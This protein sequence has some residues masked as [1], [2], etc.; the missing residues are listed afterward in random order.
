MTTEGNSKNNPK[1]FKEGQAQ[2]KPKPKLKEVSEVEAKL[3][4]L[5]AEV[6]GRADLAS[7]PLSAPAPVDKPATRRSKPPKPKAERYADDDED[8]NVEPVDYE[9]PYADDDPSWGF[10]KKRIA[11]SPHINMAAFWAIAILSILLANAPGVNVLLT[12]VTQFVVMIHECSHAIVAVLTGGHPAVTIVSDGMGH[13]GITQTN[14]GWIF[15][16][17]QAGYLGTAMFGCLLIW[18]GQFPKYSRYILMG[19]GWAMILSSLIFITPSIFSFTTWFSG[20]LS[21]AWGLAIGI[22]CIIM[23]KKLKPLTANLVLLFLAV[24]TALN[25]ISLAWLLIPHSLGM[26]GAGFTDATIMQQCFFI[27]AAFWAFWWIFLSVGMLLL[28][29]RFTYGKA[30]LSGKKPKKNIAIDVGE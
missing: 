28:T 8:E 17:A 5:E 27:P 1:P 13:G 29:V 9:E 12:P 2:D 20:L 19:I 23:G 10:G 30:L 6:K 18:L 15:F 11:H 25:S 14:G 24:Q 7:D 26:A 21:M 3:A 22:A 4:K 16:T